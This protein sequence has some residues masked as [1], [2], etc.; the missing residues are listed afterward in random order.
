MA[1]FVQT[2]E[3][4]K[5]CK[6]IPSQ[7]W[8]FLKLRISNTSIAQNK[9]QTLKDEWNMMIEMDIYY[10]FIFKTIKYETSSIFVGT[11]HNLNFKFGVSDYLNTFKISHYKYAFLAPNYNFLFVKH[12]HFYWLGKLGGNLLRCINFKI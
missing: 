9:K 4:P 5:V 3:G 11:F 6:D 12:P 10:L 2:K 1:I 8:R 7:S